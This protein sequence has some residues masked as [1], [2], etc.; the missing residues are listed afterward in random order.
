MDHVAETRK[1]VQLTSWHRPMQARG[2][3]PDIDDPVVG[4]GQDRDRQV[5]EFGVLFL[6]IC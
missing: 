3:P 5:S 1:H 2:L 6:R 4:A